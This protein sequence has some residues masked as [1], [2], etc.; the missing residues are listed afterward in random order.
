MSDPRYPIGHFKRPAGLSKPERD[1]LIAEVEI[2]PKCL[3]DVL[4]DFSEPMI[5]TPYREGGWTLGQVVHHLVDSHINS[6]C[7][8]KLGLTEKIPVIRPYQEDAW[9]R[10]A[11]AQGSI[12]DAVVLLDELHKRWVMLLRSMTD[13]EFERVIVHPDSGEWTLAQM[14]ALYAW[15]GKHH[16]AHIT[17]TKKTNGW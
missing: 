15:H 2:L 12:E 10:T 13:D 16:L 5:Q 9:A 17:E 1:L 3:R 11:D 14:L 8:F 6:F 7:R 4:R